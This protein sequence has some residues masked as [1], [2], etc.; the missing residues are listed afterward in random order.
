MF[1]CLQKQIRF[2]LACTSS[3]QSATASTLY[4][5]NTNSKSLLNECVYF[6]TFASGLINAAILSKTS[7]FASPTVLISATACLFMFVTSTT[8]LSTA[9]RVPIPHRIRDKAA[10]EPTPPMPNTATVAPANFFTASSP[11]KILV[12]CKKSIILPF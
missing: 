12:L 7:V 10:C 11:Y 5:S 1:L 3:M 2:S 6:I 4:L 8:S 9:I